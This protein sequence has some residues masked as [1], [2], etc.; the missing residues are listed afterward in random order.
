MVRKSLVKGKKH[1]IL[2]GIKVSSRQLSKWGKTGGRPQQ[3]L[4]GAERARAF[5]L[6]K[7]QEKFGK[8]VEL[9]NYRSYEEKPKKTSSF[10]RLICDKC[11]SKSIGGLGHLNQQCFGCY[12]GKMLEEKANNIIKRA[13]NSRERWRRF[14]E[15]EN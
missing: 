2:G 14:R 11:Q 13:G 8:E 15:K 3:Y 9:R 7:K 1:E 12:Q 10:V 4:N 6:R 5:R